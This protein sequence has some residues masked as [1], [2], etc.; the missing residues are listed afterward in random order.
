MAA[1][2]NYLRNKIIDSTF[3]GVAFPAPAATYVALFNVTAGVSPRTAAVT[4][5]QTTVPATPN[6]HL[7]RATTAGTTGAAE[8]TWP[9]AAGGTVTD[10]TATW[11]EATGDFQAGTNLTEVAG[12]AYARASLAPTPANWAATNAAGSTVS[13]STGATGQT[14]N[15]P[16]ITFPAATGT[17]WGTVA[18][19]AT[20]D[21]PTA[22][23]P[24]TFE[25]LTAT[26]AVPSGVAPNFPPAA[27]SLT[28]S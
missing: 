8:P 22:G 11:T 6:G 16:V 27:L 4:L 24:L 19:C 25:I 28:L 15:N 9:L 3:R 5:G 21:A 2:T 20:F 23:N 1:L 17:G 18:A 12:N 14:S 13:P 7:Y 10:G 26:Q